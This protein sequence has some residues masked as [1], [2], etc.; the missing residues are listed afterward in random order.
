MFRAEAT[1]DSTAWVSLFELQ[2]YSN[3]LYESQPQMFRAEAT[4]DTTAWVLL[5]KLQA[6]SNLLY[7]SFAK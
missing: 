1:P 3:L 5:F 4:P 2:A 7:E 6:Y